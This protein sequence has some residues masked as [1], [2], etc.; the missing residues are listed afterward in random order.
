MTIYGDG[1]QVRDYLLIDDAIEA[2]RLALSTQ[3]EGPVNFGT[4]QTVTILYLAQK[5]H[6]LVHPSGIANKKAAW[7][8]GPP[9]KGE[10]QHL[11]CDATK[12][13]S[14]GWT[15]KTLFDDGLER[16]VQVANLNL[17]SLEMKT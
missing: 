7:V 15:P 10:V 5:I 3:F 16:Y 4:G 6:Q 1:S 2:Y 13:R 9:R 11:Q 8:F 14:L 12:A 17:G